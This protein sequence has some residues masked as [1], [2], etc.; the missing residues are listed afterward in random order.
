MDTV[1]RHCRCKLEVIFKSK[2]F[3]FLLCKNVLLHYVL[4]K[5]ARKQFSMFCNSVLLTKE[6]QSAFAINHSSFALTF[7]RSSTKIVICC[8]ILIFKVSTTPT[9]NKKFNCCK[10]DDDS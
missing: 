3:T 9:N 10:I 5:V 2:T 6:K 4:T 7:T 1:G 8:L